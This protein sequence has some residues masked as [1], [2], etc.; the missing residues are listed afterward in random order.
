ML[1]SLKLLKWNSG[2]GGLHRCLKSIGLRFD[3][4]GFHQL[5][6]SSTAGSCAKLL[7]SMSLVRSQPEQPILPCSLMVERLTLN[8]EIAVRFLGGHPI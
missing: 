8:Q 2:V 3:P 6:L 4:V 5:L 1:Q 7:I